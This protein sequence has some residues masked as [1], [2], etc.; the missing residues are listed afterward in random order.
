MPG[1]APISHLRYCTTNV[2]F[3]LWV[4]AVEPE[5]KLPITVKL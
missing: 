2:S 4:N 1:D 5:V 3:V